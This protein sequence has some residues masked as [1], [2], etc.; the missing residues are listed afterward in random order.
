MDK[1]G[2]AK[3]CVRRCAV[4]VLLA[5][6]L[7]TELVLAE[8]ANGAMETGVCRIDVKCAGDTISPLLFG[9]NLKYMRRAMWQ[10]LSAQML[11]NRKF[12]GAN[13]AVYW[14]NEKYVRGAPGPDGVAAHWYGIGGPEASFFADEEEGFTG[15][16]SQRI[17]RTAAGSAGVGQ[18]GLSVLDGSGYEVR[19]QVKVDQTRRVAASLLPDDH[20]YGM[21]RDVIALLK[22]FSVPILRW[23]GGNFS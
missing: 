12:A 3:K 19:I 4:G 5:V 23:P 17:E 9:H 13:T 15:K 21:R 2:M 10:G 18:G 1:R 22:E 6:S 7:D 11:A 16:Q 20:Q 8:S 14:K